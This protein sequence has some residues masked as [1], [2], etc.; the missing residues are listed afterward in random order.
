MKYPTDGLHRS[1]QK[2][3][4]RA[5]S[6]PTSISLNIRVDPRSQA[7]ANYIKA[8]FPE[9]SITHAQLLRRALNV[10]LKQLEASL[11]DPS[12]MQV[13]ELQLKA[14]AATDGVPWMNQ[15]DFTADP[16]KPFSSYVLEASQQS[17]SKFLNREQTW[18]MK[19]K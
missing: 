18:H 5:A 2:Q 1:H 10:Y 3:Q 19:Q 16:S 4:Q 17:L 7:I 13:E 6:K 11:N 9:I 12:L 8:L 14:S 15:P